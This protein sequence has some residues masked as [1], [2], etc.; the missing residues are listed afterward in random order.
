MDELILELRDS[1]ET[2]IV[3]VTH[4]LE[5]IFMIGNNAVYLDAGSRTMLATGDPRRLRDESGD[6][7]V[8]EFL[9]GGA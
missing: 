9:R 4:A 2:T 8:R 5:S 1:L 6:P 3:V 7:R